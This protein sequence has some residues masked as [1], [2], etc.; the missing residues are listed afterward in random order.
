MGYSPWG[1]QRV[2]QDLVS[3]Q[4]SLEKTQRKDRHGQAHPPGSE[5]G[6]KHLHCG[7]L[8]QAAGTEG[9]EGKGRRGW[10]GEDEGR[11]RSEGKE[12]EWS[13]GEG[14]INH[15]ILHGLN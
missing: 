10:G 14:M 15:R 1:L 3:K 9:G 5:H 12:G 13:G 6:E 7:H 11:G 4:L 2:G 8:P